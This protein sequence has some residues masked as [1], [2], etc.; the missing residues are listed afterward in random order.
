MKKAKVFRLKTASA[1]YQQTPRDFAAS[2]REQ[3]E[4]ARRE[5]LAAIRQVKR[6][7]FRDGVWAVLSAITWA[8]FVAIM[9]VQA[10]G[11]FNA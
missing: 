3:N 9:F 8:A 5:Q 6:A 1:K 7:G 2:I 10:T 4:T 11:G